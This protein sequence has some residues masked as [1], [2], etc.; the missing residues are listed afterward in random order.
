MVNTCGS[1][2]VQQPPGLQGTNN[3]YF[4][5]KAFIETAHSVHGVAYD[6]ELVNVQVMITL[7]DSK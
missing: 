7:L 6:I 1:Q 2:T 4:T 5:K 3:L